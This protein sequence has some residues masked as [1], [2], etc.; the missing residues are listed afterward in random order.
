VNAQTAYTAGLWRQFQSERDRRPYLM[1]SA[2][3]D[4]RTR[5][6]HRAMSGYI[7]HIDDA[8]WKKWTPPCGFNCRCTL[9][10]LTATQA[11]ERGYGKQELP[12]AEPDAGFGHAVDDVPDLLD[13]MLA[14]ALG[15]T[16][17]TV[18]QAVEEQ[19]RPPM[20]AFAVRAAL[21]EQFTRV[22]GHVQR[23]IDAGDVL[24]RFETEA[25]A[26][27]S[28]IDRQA[29]LM[30]DALLGGAPPPEL[31][32][33][34]ALVAGVQQAEGALP[35]FTGTVE[36]LV[37]RSG[38]A[39]Y[40]FER[41]VAAHMRTGA[42]V[43][44]RAFTPAGQAAAADIR[45]TIHAKHAIDT[46]GLTWRA[47]DPTAVFVAGASFRVVSAVRVEGKPWQYEVTL[48]E[49]TGTGETPDVAFAAETTAIAAYRQRYGATPWELLE[50][51]YPQFR[52]ANERLGIKG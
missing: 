4:H 3:N 16:P 15:K 33:L 10:S 7:A 27:S 44:W 30:A 12:S 51:W 22:A 6:A 41:F 45:F 28:F 36:R 37:S 2:I 31:E 25:I 34:G 48:E 43:Q 18:S 29:G 11:L 26:V 52:E 42:V 13:A 24:S 47:G 35:A 21:G 23:A 46:R 19:P 38:F 14:D 20:L 50:R 8:I 1:Y 40:E 17:V 5:P 9:I 39:P 49:V 32:R